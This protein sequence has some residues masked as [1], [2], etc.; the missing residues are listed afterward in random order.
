LLY[1]LTLLSVDLAR[2]VFVGKCL[3]WLKEIIWTFVLQNFFILTENSHIT[4]TKLH[5]PSIN[6]FKNPGKADI[7][8]SEKTIP[9]PQ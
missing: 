1:F 3:V 6:N 7:S 2:I 4:T 8:M 9:L 5:G